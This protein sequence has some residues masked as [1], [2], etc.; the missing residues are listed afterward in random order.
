MRYLLKLKFFVFVSIVISCGSAKN[1]SEDIKDVSFNVNLVDRSNDT[2][3]VEV[4]P[5]T[6]TAE[7]NIY[8][9]AATAPGTYQVMDIGRYVSV[10]KAFD[11]DGNELITNKISTNQYELSSPEKIAKIT[12]QIAETWDTPVAENDIYLMCG[13]SIEND[14]TVIN[15][16][17]VFGYFKGLQSNSIK[18]KIDHPK[19]WLVGTALKKSENGYYLADDYDHVVDSPFLIGK[20]TKSSIDI[21]GTSIDIYT[22]SKNDLIKSNQI[23]SSLKK[24]L[25]SA[26]GFLNGLP[27]NHYTFLFHF[28]DVTAGAWEHSYSSSYVYKEDAWENLEKNIVDVVAHEFFHVVTPLN[29]HS[30]IIDYFNFVTPVPSQHLWLYEGTTEWAAHMMQMR[31][32]QKSLSDYFKS[33]QL[34]ARYNYTYYNPNISLLELALTSYTIEGHKQYGNIYMKGA[35]V[36]GL[37]DI[38]LLEL[39][40]GKTGLIDVVN[41]LAK[42]YGPNKPFSDANFFDEFAAE[43]YPEV[44]AFFNSYVKNSE[45]LPLKTYYGKIGL[46]YNEDTYAFSL[47]ENPT[48]SQLSLRTRWMQPIDISQLDL[49]NLKTEDQFI[50]KVKTLD[51]TIKTLYS[52]ISGEKGVERNWELFKYLFKP[53]AKLIPSV[54]NGKGIYQ[55]QYMSPDDYIKSS[56]NWLIENG[57]FEKEISRTVDSFGNMA[58]VFSAYEA[59]N[60]EADNE[61]LLRGINSIQLLNDGERWWIVNI[62]WAQET[63]ENPIPDAYLIKD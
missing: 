32:G 7:N 30:D 14:H 50:K 36:A 58:Q 46:D 29:I 42:K 26:S 8:Q 35:L 18:I 34:M 45:K 28:E 49:A 57:F 59:F 33:L 10:F 21:Q 43:T 27:V 63:N 31:S 62:Y 56:G 44:N 9:F 60:S 1:T 4:I 15:G 13:T 47:Q 23:L 16:Q 38:R 20:L 17:A 22:Y 52:V 2:F 54:K 55:L 24:T 12:Y 5:P 53:D 40:Q 61:V 11:N 37:L 6:L 19:E 48:P 25:L 3:K 41:R 51:S 39:S